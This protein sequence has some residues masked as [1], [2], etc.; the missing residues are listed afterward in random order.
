MLFNIQGI[1]NKEFQFE[2]FLSNH[3]PDVVII[4]EHWLTAD[5][6]KYLH[7]AH[8]SIVNFYCRSVFTRGGVLFLIL[9]NSNIA[10]Q[11]K[12]HHF[13]SYEKSFECAVIALSIA[14]MFLCISLVFSVQHLA[15]LTHSSII[16]KSY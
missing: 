10:H 7:I 13:V 16:W 5:D 11:C 1:M 9:C 3:N 4:C 8:Y 14:K 12:S 15:Y 2:Q 6:I